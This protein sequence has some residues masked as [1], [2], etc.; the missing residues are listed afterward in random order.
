MA[1]NNIV[2]RIEGKSVEFLDLNALN[3]TFFTKLR[4]LFT[5]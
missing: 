2:Q 5:K 1:M 3:D 4:R